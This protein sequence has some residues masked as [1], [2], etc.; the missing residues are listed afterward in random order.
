MKTAI[1]LLRAEKKTSQKTE[2]QCHQMLRNLGVD[3]RVEWV[4]A[5]Q[6]ILDRTIPDITISAVLTI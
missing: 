5:I 2:A 1:N 3:H 4:S 6:Q